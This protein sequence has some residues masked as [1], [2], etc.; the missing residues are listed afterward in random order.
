MHRLA[1]TVA[2]PLLYPPS[3]GY[4]AGLGSASAPMRAACAAAL[5]STSE[6]LR[7]LRKAA[8]DA[9]LCSTSEL[10][11]ALTRAAC[12]AALCSTSELLRAL[13]RATGDVA[14]CSTS[15]PVPSASLPVM[16]QMHISHVV[17]WLL[18]CLA[19]DGYVSRGPGELQ[20]HAGAL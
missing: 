11:R 18:S 9:A 4:A 16:Q 8:C 13:T 2:Y 12:D 3:C 6:L 1:A 14:L 10:L 7:V 20:E 15:A 17:D 5:C 19:L